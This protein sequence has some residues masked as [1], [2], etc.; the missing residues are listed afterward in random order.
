MANRL[1]PPVEIAFHDIATV[2]TDFGLTGGLRFRSAGPTD[3]TVFW[4][5]SREAKAAVVDVLRDAGVAVD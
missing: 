1:L 4:P 2:E 3:G 5:M